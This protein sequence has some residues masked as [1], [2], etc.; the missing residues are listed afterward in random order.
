MAALA[1]RLARAQAC[2]RS[3]VPAPIGPSTTAGGRDAKAHAAL[4]A[5][6]DKLVEA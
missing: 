1:S 3:S 6:G 5:V 4:R 2:G